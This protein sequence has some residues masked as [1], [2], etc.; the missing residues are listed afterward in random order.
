[1]LY[2]HHTDH[3]RESQAAA[4]HFGRNVGL[5]Q[6]PEEAAAGP[7]KSCRSCHLQAG[8]DSNVRYPFTKAKSS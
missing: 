8:D 3:R 6:N 1:M 5:P 7:V 4:S 2:C